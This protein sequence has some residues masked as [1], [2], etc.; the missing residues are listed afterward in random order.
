MM[1]RCII[2]FVREDGTA[3]AVKLIKE[4]GA[5]TITAA[6]GQGVVAVVKHIVEA[7]EGSIAVESRPGRGSTFSFTL[8]IAA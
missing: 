4:D 2:T 8:P 5:V 6:V 1:S 3:I 7:R